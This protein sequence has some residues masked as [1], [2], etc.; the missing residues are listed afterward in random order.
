VH[1][2]ARLTDSLEIIRSA[3][4]NVIAIGGTALNDATYA[5]LAMTDTAHTRAL[6]LVF[7]DGLDNASW[8]SVEDVQ[9]AARRSDAVVYGVVVGERHERG[10]AA[11][12]RRLS[13]V[14]RTNFLEGL[15]S[16]TGGRLLKA[17][18]LGN[19]PRTFEAI[20]REFRTRYLITYYP[21][22]V[23]TA[24]WHAIDVRLKKRHGQVTAR[25]GYQR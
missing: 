7:S 3:L 14:A 25:R 15:A 13:A 17:D 8:L 6:V 16:A 23:E 10:G 12:G 1:I 18:G 21:R 4:S 9:R 22:G 19:L 11:S 20:L 2:R 24:G 5:A